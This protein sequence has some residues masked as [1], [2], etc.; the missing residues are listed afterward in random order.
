MLSPASRISLRPLAVILVIASATSAALVGC[1]STAE[2]EVPTAGTGSGATGGTAGVGGSGSLAGTGGVAGGAAGGAPTAGAA[3]SSAG[4]TGN[5][6]PDVGCDYTAALGRS[7]AIAGCHRPAMV[8]AAN[9]DLTPDAGLR[10]RLV[11]VPAKFSHIICDAATQTECVPAACPTNVKILDSANPDASWLFA[12]L[13]MTPTGC[14]DQMPM[15]PGNAPDRWTADRQACLQTF[16]RALASG[17]PAPGSGGT[18]SGGT[19]TGGSAGSATGGSAGSGG[20]A[21]APSAGSGG[22]SA[23]SG[24]GGANGGVAG[25]L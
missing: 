24:Q 5:G 10:S 8:I 3:G 19:S 25:S 23:G 2:D 15:A 1:G 13:G 14:G 6:L 16:F 7:C 4:T 22:A 11:D 12:K 18:G 20:T 21:G 17:G 9:L